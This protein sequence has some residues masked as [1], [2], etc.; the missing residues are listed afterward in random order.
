MTQATIA[1]AVAE[2]YPLCED[3]QL[4]VDALNEIGFV[5]DA[6]IWND[7]DVNWDDYPVVVVR[8]PWD[9][10]Y[11]SEQY[12]VWVESFQKNNNTHLL[13]S[14]EAIL[15][16]IDKAYLLEFEQQGIP[17]VPSV[18]LEQG[19]QE[20]LP[21]ILLKQN[22]NK[23]VIKPSISGGAWKTWCCDR[24]LAP[25]KQQKFTQQ[26][27]EHAVLIQPFLPEI[28][29]HGELSV[30]FFNGKYSHSVLKKA[31]ARDFR[32]Q[33]VHGGSSEAIEPSPD[34]I[35]QCE[36][37]LAT[38]KSELLYA[39]VDGIIRNDT[40]LL[41]ELEINEPSLFF[42]YSS[43]A[44]KAFASAVKAQLEAIS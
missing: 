31:K 9:Y 1:F 42:A 24:D 10:F 21:G 35:K 18:L 33:D 2:A 43:T 11:K 25:A 36:R 7:P 4:A 29:D 22:W 44:P 32:V 8:S 16:N 37:V 17:I 30:I 27:Q 5:V 40:F 23:V 28:V 34:T 14:P 13:N 41:M 20:N 12:R 26:L 6:Q 39:R 3:D 38:Q 19:S 15:A